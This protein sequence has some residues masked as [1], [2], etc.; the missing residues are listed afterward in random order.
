MLNH[1]EIS[2]FIKITRLVSGSV[3]SE[4]VAVDLG[5]RLISVFKMMDQNSNYLG[6]CGSVST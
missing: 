6:T 2:K 3:L 5:E 1:D 4:S